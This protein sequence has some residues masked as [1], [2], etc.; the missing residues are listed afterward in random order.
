M[1]A[2]IET[3]RIY[4]QH[5]VIDYLW[6]QGERLR[7]GIESAILHHG[8]ADS[9][10]VTGRPCN[11]VFQTRDQQGQ[12]SQSFRT[13]F[14]QELIRGGIIAPSFVVSYSHSDVD[15]DC[16]IEVVDRALGV[17]RSALEDGIE[18]YLVG[19][20]VRPVNRRFN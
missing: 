20:P 1:A 11:L 17:Y 8:L 2:A 16:T 9:F 19:R 13:L 7:V 5:G 15:I 14:L 18:K 3:I 4:E 12:P 10:A 6:K